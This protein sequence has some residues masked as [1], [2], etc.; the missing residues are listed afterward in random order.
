MHEI[1]EKLKALSRPTDQQKLLI[2][3]ADKSDRTQSD[4][5]KLKL[6]LAAEVAADRATKARAKATQLLKKES[7][8]E[9]EKDRKARN[10]RLIQQGL[11]IDFAGLETMDKGELLGVLL[12][13]KST[14][15]DDQKRAERKRTGDALLSEK[16]A[17]STSS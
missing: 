11:L 8:K 3:L 5:R 6:L 10:H 9:A 2:V 1:I 13:A 14:P 4:E 7:S 16:K 12:E 17:L 15:V